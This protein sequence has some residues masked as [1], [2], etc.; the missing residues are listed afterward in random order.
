MAIVKNRFVCDL[1]KPVQAQALKGNVFSLDNLGSRLSVLIYDNGQPATISGTITGNC[2]LPDGSTVNISGGLTSENGC[3]KAYVDVPQSCLLIPGILKIAIKCTSS[4]VITTLAAIVANVYMT[5]T[6]NVITPSQQIIT[7]WNAQISAAIATQNAAIANQDAEISDLKSEINQSMD[8]SIQYLDATVC[9]NQKY[10]S[11]AGTMSNGDTGYGA[12][13]AI[14]IP[15]GTYYYKNIAYAFTY[16]VNGAGTSS[17]PFSQGAGSITFNEPVTLYI[18]AGYPVTDFTRVMLANAVLPSSYIYGV[19]DVSMPKLTKAENLEIESDQ[20]SDFTDE[21]VNTLHNAII[22]CKQYLDSSNWDAAG[23]Y[24]NSSCAKQTG[25]D[26]AYHAYP[27]LAIKAGKYH[28]RNGG[29]LFTYFKG[30]SNTITQ[31]TASPFTVSEDGTIYITG[32]TLSDGFTYDESM[33]SNVPLPAEYVYGEYDAV[34]N[35]SK[36]KY[37]YIIVDAKGEGNFT[38]IQDAVDSIRG[39][40]ENNRYTIILMPGTYTRFSMKNSKRYISIIG[41]DS[42]YCI[43]QDDQA[44]YNRCAAEIRTNGTIANITFK[45]LATNHTSGG[46]YPYSY[47]VH[48]DYGDSVTV[49][50]NCRFYSEGGPGVGMGIYNG[51]DIVF[52]NCEFICN[53]AS[54]VGTSA[55]GALYCHASTGNNQ[56]ITLLNCIVNNM[57][58]STT[59][60]LDNGGGTDDPNKK[61]ILVNNVFWGTNG[62]QNNIVG[63]WQYEYSFG[64]NITLQ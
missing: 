14:Q 16:A 28:I 35:S 63:T 34:V 33:L 9:Q 31:I 38:N 46:T 48:N 10:Y 30:V 24:Y 61:A 62:A 52:K 23:T 18:T 50:E 60:L 25:G 2:I 7:D 64:N 27:P 8:L 40:S 32:H 55:L 17:K 19:Y 4:S 20:V 44:N 42:R 29:N 22:V 13:P 56:K 59:A 3:S 6:D 37:P 36:I 49:Y 58:G 57:T 11:S 54:G 43:V 41:L 21:I 5:K 47:A 45:N 1:S 53:Q 51:S 26:S 12:Y 15:A 39:D